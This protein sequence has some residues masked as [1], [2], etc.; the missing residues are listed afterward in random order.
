MGP[1]R[2]GLRHRLAGVLLSGAALPAL[3]LALPSGSADHARLTTTASWRLAGPKTVPGMPYSIQRA[4]FRYAF[5]CSG[6]SDPVRQDLIIFLTVR[7]LEEA[8]RDQ[9][10]ASVPAQ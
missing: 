8:P 6:G 5:T 3:V 7:M 1:D 9:N 4:P 10:L 2:S